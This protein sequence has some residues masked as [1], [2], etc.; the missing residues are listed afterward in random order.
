[1]AFYIYPTIFTA[2][3]NEIG[4]SHVSL[5]LCSNHTFMA[6]QTSSYPPSEH[7][8]TAQ[9]PAQQTQVSSSSSNNGFLSPKASPPLILAFLAIGFFSIAMI[10]TFSWRRLRD[11]PGMM[12]LPRGGGVE[13]RDVDIG[14]RPLLWD[15]W[16]EEQHHVKVASAWDRIT[17]RIIRLLR[18]KAQR[19]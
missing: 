14:Q 1:L 13:V 5:T 19:C 6:L 7:S 17:V 9:I 8:S 15:L 4:N 16:T 12:G 3:L 2:H 10:V 11:G 18:V